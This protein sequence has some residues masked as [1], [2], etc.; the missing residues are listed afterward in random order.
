MR[1]TR[2]LVCGL[3]AILGVLLSTTLS[4]TT[5]RAAA[6]N[7]GNFGPIPPGVT[8]QSVTESSGTDP[9]PLFGPPAPTPT[10]LDFDPAGFVA[11]STGANS[12]I[13]DG[14]LN[15]AIKTT[16]TPISEVSMF[17]GG[18]YSLNG[19]GPAP[20]SVFAGLSLRATITEIDNLPVAPINVPA[21]AVHFGDN[22]PPN[23]F[24]PWNLG[25]LQ[26]IDSALV[27]IPHTI[28]ATRVEVAIDNDLTAISSANS[29]ALIA[30]KEFQFAVNTDISVLIPEPTSIAL[31]GLAIGMLAGRRRTAR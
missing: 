23:K 16:T 5:V 29:T 12:D 28:G 15:F 21:S 17:E 4:V 25:L 10:G 6:I 8:F 14:Q 26:N 24:A 3:A 22:S 7:Y 19:I 9:V 2:S 13:T 27:G 20:A 18:D 1:V 31:A 30:K 11:S